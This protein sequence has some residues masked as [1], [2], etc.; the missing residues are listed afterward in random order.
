MSKLATL[1]AALFATAIAYPAASAELRIGLQDD[2]DVLD[3]AQSRTF[4]GRIVYTAMCDK[5]VDISQEMKIVPQLATEWNWSEDGKELTMTLRE[6]VK[7]HDDTPFNAQ[8]VVATIER[9]M[10]LPESRRK[11][12]LSSVEKVEATGDYEVKFTLKSPD[13]TLLAQLSDR[14]GM[15]V[16]PKAAQELGANFGS[17]PVCAGPFKFVERIQQDRIVLEKFQDYWN[18]DQVFL[19]KVTYLPIPDT[20]VRL[21]NLRS[22]DLDIAERISASDASSVKEDSNL[23]YADVIGPG[24]MAMY[25]NVGNGA[26]AENPLGQDK[27]LRQAFSLAID[28]EAINQIVFEGT[29]KAGNQPFPP[30]SPWF[31]QDLPVQPRDI[32][33]AKALMAEAGHETLDVELQH[34]NNTTQTQMMQVIQSMVAEAG[35][36]VSLRATEFATLLSEQTAGNYQLSRSDWS[37]RIDPDGN[38]HQ[39]ITCEGG[40]NDVKYCNP[41]VDQLLNDARASTDDAVRKEKYDAASVILAEDMPIIYLG[42]QPYAYAIDNGVADFAPSPD[43]MIRLVGVKNA[44]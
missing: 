30:T 3:P 32:E 2:A 29:A 33:K 20:T 16:S 44:D 27:R 31:N 13:V 8:A 1:T 26:R 4:V 12:E 38:I 14:A 18:A 7:F 22:G 40:I 41:E 24:Y 9:N 11:S 39:F 25:V 6:G 17:A 43:G 34:A 10:T 21:A 28:R 5:L 37:G 19:D 36:N 42:H 35:F 15:I 23:T